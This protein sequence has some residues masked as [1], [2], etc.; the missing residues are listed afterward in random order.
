MISAFREMTAE[1]RKYAGGK[2][3]SLARLLQA[4]YPVPDGFV[5]LPAAFVNDELTHEAWTQIQGHLFRLRGTG[6][7]TAFAVRSSAMSEDSAQASFA[8]EFETVLNVHTDEE[9][10]QAIRTVY[11]SRQNERVQAYSQAKGMSTVHEIAVVVQQLVRAESSGVLF[12][13]KNTPT[14]MAL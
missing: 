8:G 9:I 14:I 11:H 12:T 5:I 10:R 13:A 1:Q 3:G 2:G 6:S 4:G 7:K